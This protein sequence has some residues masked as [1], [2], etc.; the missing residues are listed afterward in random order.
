[1]ATN[2][3]L[4]LEQFSFVVDPPK[5]ARENVL[6]QHLCG[7]Q[8]QPEQ[9]SCRQTEQEVFAD[10]FQQGRHTSLPD[11]ICEREDDAISK[12]RYEKDP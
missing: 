2:N 5:N 4:P 8:I 7:W 10:T 9:P 11:R 1:M 6:C 12:E 3:Y